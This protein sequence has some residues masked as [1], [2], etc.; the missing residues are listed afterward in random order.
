MELTRKQAIEEIEAILEIDY[1]NVPLSK[2]ED[3]T[4]KEN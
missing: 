2:E 3:I 4:R 1:K